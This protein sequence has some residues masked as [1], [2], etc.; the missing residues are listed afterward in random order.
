MYTINDTK[1]YEFNFKQL[2]KIGILAME[3]TNDYPRFNLLLMGVRPNNV[4]IWFRGNQGNDFYVPINIQ[5]GRPD[6]LGIS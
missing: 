3:D 6:F 1:D 5:S 2:V 4:S